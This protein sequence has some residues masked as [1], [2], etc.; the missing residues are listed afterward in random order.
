[1]KKTIT[2]LLFLYLAINNGFSQTSRVQVIH[3]SP[4]PIASQVDVYLNGNL[5]LDNF[6]FRTATP[7][8]DVPAGVPVSIDIA[9]ATSTSVAESIFNITPTLTNGETYILVANGIVSQ[10]GTTAPNF[11]I[12]VFAQGH[13]V[14]SNPS[15]TEVL[16]NHGSPDAPTVD[17][18]ETS[19][20]AGTIVNDISFPNFAG[21]LELPN[22]DFTLDVRDATGTTTVAS[23][24]AP[25]QTLGLDGAAITVLASGFLDPSVGTN[26]PSFGLWVATAAG[27]NL[28]P[29]P[30][31]PL[32]VNEISND[33]FVIYPNPASGQISILNTK[34]FS[35]NKVNI[36]D[37]NGRI[38][39]EF[40]SDFSSL[41]ISNLTKG[42]YLISIET[43]ST[44]INKK[45][46][47]N[48]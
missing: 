13:E 4:D 20:P 7:F 2:L 47:I 27:G 21:Y 28:I 26:L 23:Y 37:V 36:V 35:I 25:L 24:S 18:V 32:S 30:N 1:M 33:S 14:A 11:G 31:I 9:P 15:Q 34:D 41:N 16:V 44:T 42:M 12:S 22:L 3:N 48:N 5:L 45:I 38:V 29:L 46:I 6:A 8:V 17:V 10:I 43:D 40:T 19:V 39:Q